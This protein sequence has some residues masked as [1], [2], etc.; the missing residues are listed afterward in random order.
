MSD[1]SHSILSLLYIPL[2]DMEECVKIYICM[3]IT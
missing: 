1:A 2:L 3:Q